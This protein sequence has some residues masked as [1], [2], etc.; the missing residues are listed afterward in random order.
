MKIKDSIVV[1]TGATE[2]IGRAT[3]LDLATQG[4]KVAVCAR[5]KDRLKDLV[6]RIRDEGGEV[7]SKPCDVADESQV[8]AFATAVERELGQP[9]ALINNAGFGLFGSI[10]EIPLT[11]YDEMFA[12][13]VRG[14]F[15]MTRAFLPMMRTNGSGHIINVASLAG[16]N[17]FVNGSAYAATKHAVIGMSKCLML[18]LRPD[19][20]RVTTINP[21]TVETQFFERAGMD[22]KNPEKALTSEDVASTIRH[23]LEMPDGAL[24]SDIDI[25]PAQ[26]PG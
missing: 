21:G 8:N 9:H 1:V 26:P 14:V 16:K 3:A 4:A 7:F 22:L 24:V 15:M 25:R 20:I 12:V 11:R 17:G 18:E 5:N 10:E 13:N 23:T 19:N 2:G 6:S